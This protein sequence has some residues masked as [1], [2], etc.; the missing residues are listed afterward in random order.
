MP[1]GRAEVAWRE[2]DLGRKGHQQRII[3]VPRAQQHANRQAL[4]VP[5]E[6][7]VIEGMP[8]RL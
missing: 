8:V 5:G 7:M 1:A 3:G 6:G 2:N 4:A